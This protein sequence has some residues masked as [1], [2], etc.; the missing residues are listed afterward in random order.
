MWRVLL[1]SSV[2]QVSILSAWAQQYPAAPLGPEGQR[3]RSVSLHNLSKQVVVSAEAH[4]TDGKTRPLTDQPVRVAQAREIV[5]P[6]SE[7]LDGVTVKLDDGRTL[8]AENFKE[9]GATRIQVDDNGIH[10]LSSAR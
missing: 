9:C 5:V 6:A 7:C 2:L 3:A 8:R 10:L 4:M 1:L